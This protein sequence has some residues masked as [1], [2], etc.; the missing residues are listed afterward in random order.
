MGIVVTEIVGVFAVCDLSGNAS[1]VSLVV[2]TG[3]GSMIFSSKGRT[4]ISPSAVDMTIYL[5][6]LGN[7]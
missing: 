6:I 7:Q 1:D 2:D 4:K 5:E 3:S